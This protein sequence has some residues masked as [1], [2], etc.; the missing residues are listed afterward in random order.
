[1]IASGLAWPARWGGP[2]ADRISLALLAPQ[3]VRLLIE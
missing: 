1:M 3:R 2:I